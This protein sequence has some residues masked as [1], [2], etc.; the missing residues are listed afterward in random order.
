MKIFEILNPFFRALSD[1][2]LIR[3]IVAWVLRI[4]AVLVALAGLLWFIKLVSWGIKA[5]SFAAGNET[6]TTGILL[7]CILFALIGLVWGY[8]GAGL[9]AFRAGSIAEL[10]E[11]NF[12]V[13]SI[14]SIL[15]RLNGELMFITYSLLG[16]G[17]CI[18]VWLV[19]SSPYGEMGLGML[20]AQIPFMG[21]HASGFLGGIE[22]AILLLLIAFVSIV[23]FYALA[24]GT[25]VLVEI[26]LNTRGLRKIAV[27]S[28]TVPVLTPQPAPTSVVPPPVV[29]PTVKSCKKCG[30][31]LDAG[32]TFCDECGTQAG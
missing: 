6:Q 19:S 3:M 26:A 23:V 24:E 31:T 8:I 27:D 9:L 13:L 1:G 5:E 10:E 21:R 30:Q 29:V 7:G 12:T 14:L 18:F 20:G 28:G 15:L 2:K 11:S 16:V 17:G 4:L 25:V 32:A 22:L